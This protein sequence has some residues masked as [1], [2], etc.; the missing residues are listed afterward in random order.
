[1]TKKI[2]ASDANIIFLNKNVKN[3][4]RNN[5]KCKALKENKNHL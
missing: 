1:M 5:N 2:L 4:I 3:S